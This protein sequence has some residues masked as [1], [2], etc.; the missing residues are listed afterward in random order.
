MNLNMNMKKN[1]KLN[2]KIESETKDDIICDDSYSDISDIK[3]L[4]GDFIDNNKNGID[5]LKEKLAIVNK[6]YK[7]YPHLKKDKT[8]FVK[9]IF[10]KKEKK[11]KKPVQK[12]IDF[13]EYVV[14]KMTIGEKTFYRDK[15]NNL[16]DDNLKMTG[17]CKKKENIYE[18]YLFDAE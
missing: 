16:M 11:V 7:K 4:D 6:F 14:E 5:I 1:K 17:F 12:I 13:N 9:E 3:S 8:D 15:Y 18:C 2:E 10:Y